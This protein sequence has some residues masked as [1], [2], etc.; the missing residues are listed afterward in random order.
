MRAFVS[1]A[2]VALITGAVSGQSPVLSSAP[3]HDAALVA[4][5]DSL[6][7]DYLTVSKAP[8]VSVAVLRGS[9]T[10][11]MKG[12]GSASRESRRAATASTV[13]R[14]GS[15]TKQFTSA[16][17][18]R[19]VEQGKLSLDDDMSKYLPDFPLQGHKV[20]IRQLLN[21]T[22]GI[23]SYTAD[24][25][26]AKTWGQ[27][28]TPRQL[29]GFV[30]K[31]PFDFAPG[32]GYRYNNTGYVLLGMILEKVAGHPYATHLQREFFTPL[33]LRQTSYCPSRSSDTTH[34]VGYAVEGD[35][36]KSAPYLSMTHPYSAGALCSTVRDLVKWQRAFAAG[37]VV[38]AAS[39]ARMTTP[40]TA[41]F[42]GPR[43]AY[44]YGI[45]PGQLQGK[46]SVGHGGGVHGFTTASMYF[47]DDSVNVVVFTNSDGNPD[48]LALNIA[49]AVFGM[50]LVPLP[51]PPV[52]VPLADA[53]R[54]K[55]PG[56]YD[57]N[58]L[59]GGVFTI[60]VTVE[61]GR[62]M[63]QAEGPGQGRFPLL[64]VGNLRF[65]SSADPTLFLTFTMEGGKATKLQL[66]QRGNTIEG[67]R[68]P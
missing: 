13:Y 67:P 14:I 31:T 51:R 38:S 56:V 58:R 17:I 20:T 19:L 35:N 16:A 54:D 23:H 53:D 21:H 42:T 59:N 30:D 47:P 7:G 3:P 46:R 5:V 18:M 11:T 12:Y 33:G 63:A 66:T 48:A 50:P 57:L 22:S 32:A 65:G 40:D 62:L 34:A 44:G 37:R 60:R 15:I 27:D 43:L 8:A 25:T 9:D 2:F 52:T 55:L 10:L 24:T 64:H 36:V 45:A 26:W 29:V 6:V 61:E 28:L 4:R 39:L 1:T 68:R 41:G 49:R